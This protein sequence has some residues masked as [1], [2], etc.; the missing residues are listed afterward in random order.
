ML[1]R[2]RNLVCVRASLH[3]K[4]YHTLSPL[5]SPP[6]TD[7]SHVT[8]EVTEER[9]TL[10]VELFTMAAT[11]IDGGS[12]GDAITFGLEAVTTGAEVSQMSN[13]I[14][15]T[16]TIMSLHIQANGYA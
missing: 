14:N 8:I 7:Q 10:A 4:I 3:W 5:L 9:A 12:D 2:S 11:D 15:D 6:P 16:S 1:L 13:T